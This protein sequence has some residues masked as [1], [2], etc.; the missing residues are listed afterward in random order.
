MNNH[1]F[2]WKSQP[3][4]GKQPIGNIMLS[5]ATYFS[6]LTFSGISNFAKCMNLQIIS[7]TTFTN[8]S[9]TLV[10]PVID[11]YYREQQNDILKKMK[12]KALVIC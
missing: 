2:T 3:F 8:N 5:A 10:L 4:V 7:R 9:R 1:K 11:M 6:G 12:R